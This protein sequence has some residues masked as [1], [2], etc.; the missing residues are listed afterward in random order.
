MYSLFID[1]HAQD[2]NIC[3]YKDGKVLK[4]II[5]ESVFQHSVHTLPLIKDLLTDFK[6]S[7]KDIGLIIV[8]N[9]P[10][11]FT[12]IRIGVTIAKTMAY[13]L[14]IPIKVIDS[15]VIKAISLK[16]DTKY[17]SIVDR[18]GAYVASFD[19]ENKAKEK[20]RYINLKEYNDLDSKHKYTD[21]VKL[22]F[23]SIYKYCIDLP[24]INPHLVNPLYVKNIDVD[25]DSKS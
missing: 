5:K 23:A 21:K 6:L 15:L 16:D 12:G 3:L 13:S 19:K 20:Y 25:H 7:A 17:V 24:T 18:H 22:D 2:I 1:T 9:G 11:S 8:V 4:S 10:G 14:N